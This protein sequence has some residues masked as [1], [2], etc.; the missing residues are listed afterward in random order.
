MDI[1]E[2]YANV[3]KNEHKISINNVKK[4]MFKYVEYCRQLTLRV[5]KF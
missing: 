4:E 2:I 5:M 1:I 3:N